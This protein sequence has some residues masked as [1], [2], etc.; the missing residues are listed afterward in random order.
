MNY[1]NSP[2][3]QGTPQQPQ[4]NL[5]QMV[6]IQPQ[7]PLAPVKSGD[8]NIK[9]GGFKFSVYK[10]EERP[11]RPGDLVVEDDGSPVE[12]KRRRGRP[13]K[14]E[15]VASSGIITGDPEDPSSAPTIY[16]YQETTNML[17]AT[18]LQIEQTT[19][20]IQRDIE[21]V[22]S[23]KTLRNKYNVLGGLNDN[24]TDLINAKITC[25]KEINN[26]ISKSNDMDYKK[27]KDRQAAQSGVNDDKHIM[28][29]YTAFLQN[30]TGAGSA[31]LGPNG[32]DATLGM[33][34]VVRTMDMQIPQG[35]LPDAGFLSYVANMTPE[36]RLMAVEDNPNIKQVV[37]YD[38]A[39]SNKAFQ[40][41]D[42][43]TMQVIPGL[44]TRDPMFM[45]GVTIDLKNH[46]AKNMDLNE[47][48]PLVIVNEN[49]VSEY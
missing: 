47:T 2:F 1:Y 39:T 20:E 9:S 7:M 22:R 33:N 35:T 15:T 49:V 18:L 44:P 19:Q 28:D 30:P 16:S 36:Q 37:V 45:E 40:M 42:M 32:I 48:Y 38:A 10:D 14:S 4:V 11:Y 46:I 17:H 21:L 8:D 12:Q 3:Y 41:M 26:S 27:E 43:S 5:S 23:N 6:P 24:R 29:L 34:G 25:I 13:R 31:A